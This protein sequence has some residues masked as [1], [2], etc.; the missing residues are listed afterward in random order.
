MVIFEKINIDM[1]IMKNIDIAKAFLKN[2]NI[3]QVLLKNIN[4]DIN[5]YGKSLRNSDIDEGII[6]R[7]ID[8]IMEKMGA[9]SDNF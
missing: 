4:I 3:D 6:C 5:I 8:K 7:N 9:K 1:A 2:N